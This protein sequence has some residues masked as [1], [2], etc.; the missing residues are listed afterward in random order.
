MRLT[1][2]MNEILEK[3]AQ[4][5]RQT[6]ADSEATSYQVTVKSPDLIECLYTLPSIV[7]SV[8]LNFIIDEKDVPKS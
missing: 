4:S 1:N 6:L 3:V 5:L 2:L 8:E 7:E